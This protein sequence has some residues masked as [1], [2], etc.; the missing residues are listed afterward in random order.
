VSAPQRPTRKP[1]FFYGWIIVVVVAFGG[2]STS[3]E[4]FPVLGVF[5]KPITEDLGWTR[6][7]F[8]A[9][10]SVG[11]LLGGLLAIMV[12]PMVDRYG[13]RWT[14][15]IAFGLLGAS[16]VLMSFM[17]SLWQYF[18]IQMVARS[19]NTGVI[20]VATAVIIPNWFIAKRGKALSM[21]AI[22]F[23][24]GGAVMPI[25]VQ[26]LSSLWGWRAATIGAGLIIW[27]VSMIPTALF[28][29]RRP[30]DQGLLPD[31]AE[32][33][34]P[35]ANAPPT[36][37]M[38]A[39]MEEPAITLHSALRMPSFYLILSAGSLWWFGRTGLVLHAI[40]YL[41][42]KGLSPGVAVSAIVLHSTIAVFGTFAAGFLRDHFPIRYVMAVHFALTALAFVIV[43]SI[44]TV[45]MVFAWAVF[46][47]ALQGMA[48]PFQRLIF[49]DYFGRR[50]LGSITGVSRAVQNVFQAAGPLV[51]AGFYDVTNS[52]QL[53]FTVFI[54]VN[55]AAVA[56]IVLARP[57]QRAA[58]DVVASPVE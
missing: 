20:A 40:P 51:A 24:I 36:K 35:D 47:G 29:R 43:L 34:E 19:M 56:A 27:G 52:Y 45:W 57:P 25:V 12:G 9:P 58:S 37:D 21:S 26:T 7:Q 46:Y 28:I 13:S 2:F 18:G 55:V 33:A 30:E 49:A 50:H 16:F 8:T 11:G 1:R 41:T 3:T 53:I 6:A 23:P 39:G 4:S 32:P 31:G 48:N 54:F 22:G 17:G 44:T 42:D 38:R 5:L 10:I 15:T 14:L